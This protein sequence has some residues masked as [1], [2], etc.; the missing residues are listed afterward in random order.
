MVQ[1]PTDFI[2]HVNVLLKKYALMVRS[3]EQKGSDKMSIEVVAS[4]AQR[5]TI[6]KFMEDLL[7][8]G[9]TGVTTNEVRFIKSYISA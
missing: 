4:P 9:Y 8:E 1:K 7:K 3:I 2:A 6:A 5:D